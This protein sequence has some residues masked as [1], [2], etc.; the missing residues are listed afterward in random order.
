MPWS[1]RDSLTTWEL[2][3][4][5]V[6]DDTMVGQTT[7]ELIATKELQVRQLMPRFLTEGDRPWVGVQVLNTSE[8]ALTGLLTYTLTGAEFA[9]GA[10]VSMEFDV[11]PGKRVC[12]DLVCPGELRSRPSDCVSRSRR[13]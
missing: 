4:K 6:T 8:V 12:R 13:Q 1:C 2:I 11:E 10:S 9:D 5:A 3:A 7:I